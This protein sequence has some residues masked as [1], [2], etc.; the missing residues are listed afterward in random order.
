[1]TGLAP[2]SVIGTTTP[3]VP[4]FVPSPT[5]TQAVEVTQT[6]EF[7]RVTLVSAPETAVPG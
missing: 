7:S 5:A 4:P 2:P 3:S 1:M 6:T